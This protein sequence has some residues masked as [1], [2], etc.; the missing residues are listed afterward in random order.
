[1]ARK[2]KFVLFSFA[3]IYTTRRGYF[4]SII[5]FINGELLKTL[6]SFALPGIPKNRCHIHNLMVIG[7]GFYGQ[8]RDTFLSSKLSRPGRGTVLPLPL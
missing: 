1:L 8:G 2:Y 3:I 6:V 4:S 7:N 5:L